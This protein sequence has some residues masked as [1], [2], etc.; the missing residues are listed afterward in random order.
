MPAIHVSIGSAEEARKGNTEFR[1]GGDGQPWLLDA[2]SL[3]AGMAEA[4]RP[5]AVC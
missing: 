5:M 3:A 4:T 1:G 2:D